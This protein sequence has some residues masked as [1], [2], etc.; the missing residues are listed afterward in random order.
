MRGFAFGLILLG[1]VSSRAAIADG[2]TALNYFRIDK[3][4][5]MI[6]GGRAS[7]LNTDPINVEKD[8]TK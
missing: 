3:Q 5:R 8:L 4:N 2:N 1:I 6:F 7:Y